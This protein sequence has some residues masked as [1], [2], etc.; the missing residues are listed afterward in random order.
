MSTLDYRV[1]PGMSQ[2][3][4]MWNLTRS[5][6]RLTELQDQISSGKLIRR[7]SDSPVGVVE[8]LRIR[9][10][11]RRNEQL[12]RNLTDATS[13]LASADDAMTSAVDQITRVRTLAVQS[14]NAGL[15]TNARN[16]LAS[17][18]DNIRQTLIG[19]ANTT[20]GDRALFA[21]TAAGSEAYDSSG[22]YVGV[23]AAVER[24]V[25]PGVKVQV[26]VNGDEIFGSPGAD[27]FAVISQLSSAIRSGDAPGIDA[28]VQSLDTRT[29]GVQ[30]ALSTVGAR[31]RRIDSLKDANMAAATTLK[32]QLGDVEDIDLP[33]VL[34]EM[35]IQ[36]NAYQAALA[37]TARVIQPSLVDFLR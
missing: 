12:S 8:S 17:E 11:V 16:A 10:D 9:G 18:I 24:A 6:T 15:D 33:K 19:I 1:T 5:M 35:Q 23:S 30:D 34:T 21:G 7:P 22:T 29:Q 32:S 37:T 20:I 3:R 14:K 4:V 27:L 13:W 36:Q 31:A 25:A 28:A 2:R 26:N